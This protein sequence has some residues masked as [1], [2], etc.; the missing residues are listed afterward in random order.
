[1]GPESTIFVRA[2]SAAEWQWERNEEAVS[3]PSSSVFVVELPL[4]ENMTLTSEFLQ[5]YNFPPID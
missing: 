1:M 2:A 5:K 3:F 4:K